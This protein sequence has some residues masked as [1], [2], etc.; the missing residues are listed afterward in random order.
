[1]AKAKKISKNTY[2]VVCPNCSGTTNFRESTV[3]GATKCRNCGIKIQVLPA[4]NAGIV[5]SCLGC[6]VVAV[7]GFVVLAVVL[8]YFASQS[9]PAPSRDMA[10]KDTVPVGPPPTATLRESQPSSQSIESRLS[11]KMAE[12]E[13]SLADWDQHKDIDPEHEQLMIRANA[14]EIQTMKLSLPSAP[15][16]EMRNWKSKNGKFEVVAKYVSL[17]SGKLRI[18]KQGGP[19]IDVELSKLSS[20]DQAFAKSV[21]QKFKS[22]QLALK[23]FEKKK[24]E[25]QKDND[26]REDRLENSRIPKPVMPTAESVELELRAELAKK[27]EATA[28]TIVGKWYWRCPAKGQ[29]NWRI[30]SVLKRRNDAYDLSEVSKGHTQVADSEQSYI[31]RKQD[32]I[33]LPVDDKNRGEK[34]SPFKIDSNG[35][36]IH[37]EREVRVDDAILV[38][39]GSFSQI[40]YADSSDAEA[41]ARKGEKYPP[42]V[43]AETF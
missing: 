1:M 6:L 23:K 3:G 11:E 15:V 36:R 10:E 38:E 8:G 28:E 34:R 26:E 16:T 2:Q 35:D 29:R 24:L 31:Y 12:Y 42:I 19:E 5:T 21:S 32:D 22:H 14:S 30:E 27:K 40:N 37:Y 43:L 4:S 33:F 7:L 41:W 39:G 20:K 17:E 18:A 9:D 13:Q 25:I